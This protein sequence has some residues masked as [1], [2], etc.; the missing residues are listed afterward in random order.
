MTDT[1]SADEAEGTV[2]ADAA[3]GPASPAA[4]SVATAT[5]MARRAWKGTPPQVTP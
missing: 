3:V 4:T 1:R 2:A 5:V